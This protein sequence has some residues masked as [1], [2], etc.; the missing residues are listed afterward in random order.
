MGELALERGERAKAEEYFKQVIDM[1]KLPPGSEL[2]DALKTQLNYSIK[3]ARQKK[4]T[5]FTPASAPS[6]QTLSSR[7]LHELTL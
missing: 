2:T 3:T 6:A 5:K 7:R 1:Q 4:P